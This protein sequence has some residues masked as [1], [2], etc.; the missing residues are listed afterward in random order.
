MTRGGVLTLS[1]KASVGKREDTSGRIVQEIL[2]GQGII[3][4]FYEIIP[5][6]LE[7]ISSRLIDWCDNKALDI[8]VTTGGTGLSPRDVTPEATMKVIDKEVP[9]MEEAMRLKSLAKTPN[10]MISRAVVG[11]RRTTLIVNLPGSPG[12]VRDC[13]DAIMKAIPHALDKIA[14]DMTECAPAGQGDKSL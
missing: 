8:I 9:G 11:V 3:T 2:Q 13:L 1:D 14:G 4:A 12:G 10:A 7:M 6:D 5:D